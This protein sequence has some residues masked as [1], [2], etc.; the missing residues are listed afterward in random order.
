VQ[1]D[2]LTNAEVQLGVPKTEPHST[3]E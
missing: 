3:H 1:L 2:R